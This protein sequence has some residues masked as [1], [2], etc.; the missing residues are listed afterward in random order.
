[1]DKNPQSKLA[2]PWH[3][4]IHHFVKAAQQRL[5]EGNDQSNWTYTYTEKGRRE[6]EGA[7]AKAIESPCFMMSILTTRVNTSQLEFRFALARQSGGKN[8]NQSGE[9]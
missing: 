9:T 7:S 3:L 1:M 2:Q 6:T 8:L 5:S 4:D